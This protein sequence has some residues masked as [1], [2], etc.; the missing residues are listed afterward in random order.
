MPTSKPFSAWLALLICGL[1]MPAWAAY[2]VV[3][4]DGRI[5]YTDRPPAD[6]AAQS[7]GKA[8][9]G[10]MAAVA[11]PFELKQLANRHPVTLYTGRECAFCDT[12]RQI[13]RSRGIPHTEKTVNTPE[14]IRALNT[15]VGSNQL[16]TL[17]VGGKLII[18]LQQ[19]EWNTY[20]DAAGYPQQSKLPVGY[21]QPDA[22]P[23]APPK[24]ES[25]T[26]SD[27]K[28][29]GGDRPPAPIIGSP[30]AGIRF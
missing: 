28:R 14:D 8:Q 13:L 16:P 9:S 26:E 15:Q 7:V 6:Q 23:L 21:V 25:N 5:T 30:P 11:L 1:M 22:L 17:R 12:A 10:A 3:G 27:N 20:L 19:A 2:K 4:P 29:E 24:P 18:G